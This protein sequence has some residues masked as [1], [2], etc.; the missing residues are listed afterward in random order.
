MG[1][2]GRAEAR[3]T[4]IH[5]SAAEGCG[6]AGCGSGLPSCKAGH[7][8]VRFPRNRPVRWNPPAGN[9]PLWLSL[10]LRRVL[11]KVPRAGRAQ[12]SQIFIWLLLGTS[13]SSQLCRGAVG[14]SSG[15]PPHRSSRTAARGLRTCRSSLWVGSLE[16][17]GVQPGSTQVLSEPAGLRHL[18]G[19]HRVSAGDSSCSGTRVVPPHPPQSRRCCSRSSLPVSSRTTI[20]AALHR[21]H[22]STGLR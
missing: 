4:A 17:V 15:L 13:S 20:P 1:R 5:R 22:P 21:C 11:L 3:G 14:Q 2:T 7:R 19:R 10:T 18:P 6:D 9:S 12:I 8:R 16:P